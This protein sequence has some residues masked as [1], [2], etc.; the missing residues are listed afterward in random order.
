MNLPD[1][2]LTSLGRLVR[3]QIQRASLKLG[4]KPN[5]VY[6]PAP[7]LA[8]DA[9][10]LTPDGALWRDPAGGETLDIHHAQH[11][12][13]RNSGG[14]NDLSLGFT[15][16]YA[17]LRARFGPHL[18]DGLAGENL[19][20][21]RP[22]VTPLSALAGGLAVR[23]AATGDLVPLGE[24]RVAAPCVEFSRYAGRSAAAEDVKAALQFL[25]AG[26]RGFYCTYSG[27]PITLALGDE[28]LAVSA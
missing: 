28:L 6:D 2:R 13:T 15:G 11:P 19:L 1:H 26:L 14:A 18:T 7:L 23:R 27:A 12:A 10:T 17:A 4:E 9:L 24:V 25:D 20:V 5:R 3:L 8:V 21:E 16:H 22:G